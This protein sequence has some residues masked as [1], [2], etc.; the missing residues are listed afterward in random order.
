[1]VIEPAKTEYVDWAVKYNKH[2]EEYNKTAPKDRQKKPIRIFIPGCDFYA[3]GQVR[4]DELCLN[5]FE[6]IRINENYDYKV[7]S[8]IDK[9]KSVLAA[10]FP[11]Q[12]ILPT[13]IERLLYK[14]YIDKMW[15]TEK[16][17]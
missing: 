14:I 2:V 8:H 5:P 3:K 15:I 4:P 9:L 7:L 12:E 10:A 1:M 11:T 17:M 16:R 13:V 6:V